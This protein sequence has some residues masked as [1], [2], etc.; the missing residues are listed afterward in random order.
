MVSD[1]ARTIEYY[2]DRL[3]F[4]FVMGVPAG[5]QEVVKTFDKA[6]PLDF[7]IMQQGGVGLMFQSRGSLEEEL[8]QMRGRPIGATATFYIE[9]ADV[10]RLYARL[11]DQ[12]EIAA[13][14]HR[15]FYGKEEFAVQDCNG[16]F[17]W[18]AGNAESSGR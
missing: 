1:V 12:V 9:V 3:G 6:Q 10:R 4:A 14:L 15:T 18:F 8:P 17:L 5:S 16:Y 13:E 2:R 11:A 7:A